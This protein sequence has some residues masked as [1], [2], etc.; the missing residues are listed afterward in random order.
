MLNQLDSEEAS[1]SAVKIDTHLP[2]LQDQ[3]TRW[4]WNAYKAVSQEE[5]VKKV[6]HPSKP[7]ISNT[8]N[9]NRHSKTVLSENGTSPMIA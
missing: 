6:M 3:S 9:M 1:E 2:V 4:I 7:L 8:H 5:L